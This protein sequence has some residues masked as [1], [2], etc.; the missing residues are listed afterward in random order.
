VTVS[1]PTQPCPYRGNVDDRIWIDP[2]GK[3][4][5]NSCGTDG[6]LL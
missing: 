5:D 4:R 2:T 6:Q 3:G 1:A